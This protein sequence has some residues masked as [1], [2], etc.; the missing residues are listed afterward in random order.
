MFI[1]LWSSKFNILVEQRSV[2][3]LM[4]QRSVYGL[5]EQHSNHILM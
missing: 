3:I 5:N 2:D 4:E 1:F